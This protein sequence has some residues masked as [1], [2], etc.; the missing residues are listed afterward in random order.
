MIVGN[1]GALFLILRH[2]TIASMTTQLCTRMSSPVSSSHDKL[3]KSLSD[4]VQRKVLLNARVLCFLSVPMNII[5]SV[6]HSRL[7]DRQSLVRTHVYHWHFNLIFCSF[8]RIF[9]SSIHNSDYGMDNLLL[10]SGLGE[11]GEGLAAL[12]LGVLDDT[13]VEDVVLVW[14]YFS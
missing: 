11:V 3:E 10:G 14:L 12:E 7:L 9:V 4:I 5:P 8:F 2:N 13:C 6:F 1:V